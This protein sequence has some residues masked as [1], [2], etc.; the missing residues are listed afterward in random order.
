MVKSQTTAVYTLSVPQQLRGVPTEVTVLRRSRAGQAVWVAMNYNQGQRRGEF[1]K[2]HR[3]SLTFLQNLQS[4][5]SGMEYEE[6]RTPEFRYEKGPEIA[7]VTS[8][9]DFKEPLLL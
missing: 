3:I 8:M 2:D 5:C 4:I 1:G 7:K 9:Y 6:Q